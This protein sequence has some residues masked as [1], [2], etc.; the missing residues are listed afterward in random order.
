MARPKG[1][2]KLG[3]RKKGTPN[4][5]TQAAKDAIAEAFQRIGGVDR[6]VDWIKEDPKNETAFLTGVY[7]KLI[8]VQLAGDAENP[9]RTIT[10]IRETIV[11]AGAR[12]R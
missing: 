4:K 8:P 1:Q 10:E 12:D 7:P 11:D 5:V 9:L 2:P 3:G 6:L